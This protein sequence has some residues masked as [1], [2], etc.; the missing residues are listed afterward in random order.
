MA[1][2]NLSFLSVFRCSGSCNTSIST[3]LHLRHTLTLPLSYSLSP[4]RTFIQKLHATWR[5]RNALHTSYIAQVV[6]ARCPL[7]CSLPFNYLSPAMACQVN[8]YS[9][10]KWIFRPIL[11]G[12]NTLGTRKCVCMRMLVYFC[13]L[14][15]KLQLSATAAACVTLNILYSFVCWTPHTYVHASSLFLTHVLFAATYL[16]ADAVL[17][18][19]RSHF[20]LYYNFLYSWA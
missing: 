12:I 3:Y 2:N 10:T 16:P 18:F 19:F 14:L 1:T 5:I 8:F 11:H 15:S 17:S 6:A 13:E 4:F 20:R 9:W 7:A